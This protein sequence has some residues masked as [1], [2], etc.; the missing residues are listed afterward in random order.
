MKVASADDV[1]YW[2]SIPT[3]PWTQ[4]QAEK[5]TVADK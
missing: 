1:A 5:V 3:P 4:K 2:M